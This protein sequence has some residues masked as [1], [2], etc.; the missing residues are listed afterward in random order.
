LAPLGKDLTSTSIIKSNRG[1]GVLGVQSKTFP[2]E[3]YSAF[4]VRPKID[5][6]TD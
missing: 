5:R 6:G 1:R 4:T 3:W 2:K